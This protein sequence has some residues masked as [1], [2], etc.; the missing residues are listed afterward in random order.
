MSR[1][2]SVPPFPPCA[3]FALYISFGFCA[4]FASVALYL[5]FLLWFLSFLLMSVPSLSSLSFVPSLPFVY[6]VPHVPFLPILNTWIWVDPSVSY[7]VLIG[8]LLMLSSEWAPMISR[9][10]SCQPI[11]GECC[12]CGECGWTVT[13]LG[14]GW[15]RLWGGLCSDLIDGPIGGLIWVW[16]DI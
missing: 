14:L 2:S 10:D 11:R 15:A 5:M 12:V 13:M 3:S 7:F 9:P 4:S 8:A 16:V 6:P 1:L